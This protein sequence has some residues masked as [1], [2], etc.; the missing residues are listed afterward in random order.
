[1]DSKAF[2]ASESL[3]WK[4]VA[5]HILSQCGDNLLIF[6]CVFGDDNNIKN[7]LNELPQF[8]RDIVSSW[9]KAGGSICRDNNRFWEIRKQCIWNNLKIKH[10]NKMLYFSNWIK[11][12]I[13]H[14]D[15]LLQG[16]GYIFNRL[17]SKRNW[18]CEYLTIMKS[19]PRQWK[20]LLWSEESLC[21]QVN[22]S[23]IMPRL[24][25]KIQNQY[26]LL[27]NTKT[28]KD[29]Y[30]FIVRQQVEK[31][32]IETYW[33]NF[34]NK[35]ETD[36][37]WPNVWHFISKL[38]DKRLASFK[39]KMLYRILPCKSLLRVWKPQE[40]PSDTCETCNKVDDYKHLYTE[41]TKIIDFIDEVKAFIKVFYKTNVNLSSIETL[42]YGYKIRHKTYFELNQVILIV[43]Y[44]IFKYSFCL[45]MTPTLLHL[46]YELAIRKFV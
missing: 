16:Q 43:Y 13:L 2:F 20:Q 41:C 8:Y 28:T 24:Y 22:T 17:I 42:I 27:D 6:Q 9:A 14:I 12:G 45:S 44:T 11:S 7:L 37:I 32:Y 25:D 34:C 15:Q 36:N 46:K 21:T 19:I 38:Q 33:N 18:M 26:L 31:P 30:C 10:K 3:N 40:F 29:L 39:Y 23:R 35:L 1:M 5:K 4:H